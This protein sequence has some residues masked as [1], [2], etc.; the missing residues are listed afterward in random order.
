MIR[1][2]VC[3]IERLFVLEITAKFPLRRLTEAFLRF[4]ISLNQVNACSI[5]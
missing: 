5:K 2:L 3:Y 1:T 4:P